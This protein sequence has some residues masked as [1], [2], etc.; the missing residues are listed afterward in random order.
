MKRMRVLQLGDVHYPDA[1]SA[2]DLLDWKD[3]GVPEPLI[4]AIAPDPLANVVKALLRIIDEAPVDAM[5]ICGD[6]TSRG[7]LAGYTRCVEY[8][9]RTLRIADPLRWSQDRVHAV[10]GNH[11]VDRTLCDLHQT[12]AHR[13]FQPLADV[14]AA[15]DLPILATALRHTSIERD[16]CRVDTFSMNSCIGCG[17]TRR[18]PD[19]IRAELHRL[20]EPHIAQADVAGAFAL[21][22][23]Q[24]D[25]PAFNEPDVTELVGE[26][27]KI[28]PTSLPIVLTH[29]NLLPQPLLRIEIYTELL[30][31]GMARH[32]L[33]GCGRP[34]LYLHG[35]I[36]TDPIEIVLQPGPEPGRLVSISAPE[37][38]AGFNL[39]DVE[40]G[41]KGVPL[42]CVVTPYRVQQHG[43][44]IHSS[45]VRLPFHDS[46]HAHAFADDLISEVGSA[47]TATYLRFEDV[48]RAVRTKTGVNSPAARIADAILEGEWLGWFQVLDRDATHSHWQ[49][50]RCYP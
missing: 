13:K 16:G 2:T 25:T 12:D 4:S 48:L 19:R 8:L 44:V 30:N 18:L 14:W 3:K 47:T 41:R 29:H 22:G 21:V 36:H 38:R 11:D 45:P 49:I 33:S 40:F 9:T 46:W 7:S 20:L 10:P 42:G 17:E 32:R 23:E 15:V 39:I 27:A 34:L 43:G 37:L 35:H 50:R 6:L 31:A 26:L 5:L 28:P 24:L 1:C